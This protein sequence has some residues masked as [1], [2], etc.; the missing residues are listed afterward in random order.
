MKE[1]YTI[2]KTSEDIRTLDILYPISTHNFEI[3]EE[4]VKLLNMRDWPAKHKI[5]KVKVDET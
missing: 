4:H 3:L 2:E 1:Y 5:V